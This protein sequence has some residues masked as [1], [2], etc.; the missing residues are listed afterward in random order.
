MSK[1]IKEVE[2]NEWCI[3]TIERSASIIAVAPP[4]AGKTTLMGNIMY[5]NRNRY[6]VAKL[7]N[8]EEDGYLHYCNIFPKLFVSNNWTEQAQ[9]QFISRQRKC[10]L[11][12]GDKFVGNNAI[13]V[14]DDAVDSGQLRK[15]LFAKLFKRFSRHGNNLILLGMQEAMDFPPSIRSATS[16][17]AIGRN[18][19][20]E[21]RKKLYSN[22]G[23]ICGSYNK[24]CD[25]MD[26]LTGD[27]TFL[28]IKKR[29]E[30]NV[31]SDCV[32][33]YQTKKMPKKWTFGCKEYRKWSDDRYNT[34]FVEEV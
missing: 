7:F 29:S 17:V 22:F 25:L 19:D 16:Y 13:V 34:S 5:Y 3:E 24:F 28:I 10:K 12:N 14:I 11:E 23:G 9:E 2:I 27:H 8:G 15:P 32:F 6:P 20:V 33:Y 18:V 31:L 4:G 26:Q 1:D 30:S 21:Q